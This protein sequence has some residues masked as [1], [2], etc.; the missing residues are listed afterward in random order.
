MIN[1]SDNLFLFCQDWNS[2]GVKQLRLP[3]VDFDNAPSI[4][5]IKKGLE[6]I[7]H[8]IEKGE[9]VYVHC[10]AGRGRSVVLVMCYLIKVRLQA[11][12]TQYRVTSKNP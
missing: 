12:L 7:E 10:K 2:L 11:P 6:F 4:P 8:F 9:S 1:K 5:Q 3:T